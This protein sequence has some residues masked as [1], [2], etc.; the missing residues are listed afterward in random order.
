MCWKSNVLIKNIINCKKKCR[1][2][3][4]ILQNS[5]EIS[6]PTLKIVRRYQDSFSKKCGVGHSLLFLWVP[7][8]N[9]VVINPSPIA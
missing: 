5:E 4:T 2:L 1:E 3:R 6:E 8:V 7:G 9:L